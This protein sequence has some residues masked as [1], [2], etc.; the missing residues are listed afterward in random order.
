MKQ[1]LQEK[2]FAIEPRWFNRND[3]KASLMGFGFEVGDGWF[4]LLWEGLNQIKSSLQHSGMHGPFEVV[5]VKE[6]FGTL[7][8]YVH[9][10][11]DRIDCIIDNMEFA[12][13]IMCER[14]GNHAQTRTNLGWAL[15]MC[16]ECY[17]KHIEVRYGG[18]EPRP[19]KEK[20]Q[21]QEARAETEGQVDTNE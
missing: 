10:G 20:E 2:L 6:K 14:C 7:R 15:T 16:D 21:E 17:A 19:Y 9:G 13:G 1:E 3:L 11:T 18:K 8:F 4:Y 12:S 5:Q